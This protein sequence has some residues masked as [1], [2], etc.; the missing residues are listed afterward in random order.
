M[1]RVVSQNLPRLALF[2]L[3]I[4]LIG[5]CGSGLEGASTRE[6]VDGGEGIGDV[7]TD[8]GADLDEGLPDLADGEIAPEDTFEVNDPTDSDTLS[9]GV[10]IEPDAPE[11]DDSSETCTGRPDGTTC[12]DGNACTLGDRCSV[13]RCLPTDPLRCNDDNVCTDDTCLPSLGCVFVPNLGSCDDGDP[14]TGGLGGDRCAMG[15]CRPGPATCDD[16]NPCTR[17]TCLEDGRCGNLP[18]DSLTCEDASAC[19]SGDFCA[20]GVCIGG[21][22]DGCAEEDVC[23]GSRCAEDGLHCRVDFLDGVACDDGNACTTR[24][25]CE[26][27]LCRAGP[28]VDCG[29]DT[30]CGV[31]RCDRQEG[32]I[33]ETAFAGGKRCSDSD[34]CTTGDECDGEG[35]CV[36]TMEAPCDDQNPCTS[37]SCSATWGCSYSWIAGTCD[38]Q[39]VCTTNDQCMSGVCRG[40]VRA[41]D[42]QNACTRDSCDPLTGCEFLPLFCDDG[43]PCT[44]D[45]CDPDI[46]C[47]ATPREGA[48]DDGLS[49]TVGD[50]CVAGACKPGGVTCDDS[51]PCTVDVCDA[52]E[53]CSNIERIACPA[54]LVVIDAVGI[55]SHADGLGQWVKLRHVGLSDDPTFE[56]SGYLLTGAACDCEVEFVPKAGGLELGPGDILFGL[57]FSNPNPSPSELAPGGPASADLFDFSL[58]L[59][60]SFFIG[61]DGD[62][63]ELV[64]DSG[65]VIDRL[66]VPPR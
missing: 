30:E 54:G 2:G 3:V 62:L 49:C 5:G 50:V 44:T 47:V 9:D 64:D 51:D 24:D 7:P 4:G 43:N 21:L 10:D 13:G 18:D 36:P 15:V 53:G 48:C 63:I 28:A 35:A 33:L 19:T 29:W 16:D 55:G 32:C 31:F 14:C 23:V 12:D 42:D 61:S 6:E 59:D 39:S 20:G 56:L 25:E 45:R 58:G 57:R 40:T 26:G 65:A 46:G 52:E 66:E 27:G 17:D 38:D 41:C 22:A 60:S 37:D 34:A 11:T 8:A 1:A